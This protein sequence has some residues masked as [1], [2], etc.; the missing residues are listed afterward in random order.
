MKKEII[1][2]IILLI[3][4]CVLLSSI[5]I[6]VN[7]EGKIVDFWSSIMAILGSIIGILLSIGIRKIYNKTNKNFIYITYN[8]NDTDFANKL[9]TDL[10]NDGF[11][12][13]R[14]SDI[15]SIGET[16]TK[17]KE[18]EIEKSKLFLVIVSSNM[19]KSK[20]LKDEILIAK[21]NN[22][23]IIPIL[24]DDVEMP[25]FLNSYKLSDFRNNYKIAY[26]NLIQNI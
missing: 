24:K 4:L 2:K 15:V 19:Y 14:E 16:L 20:F 17:D 10:K 5:I 12:I 11:S 22:I 9:I 26:K 8:I 23:T 21:K 6:I 3:V 25:S 1:N 13:V 18:E 7:K